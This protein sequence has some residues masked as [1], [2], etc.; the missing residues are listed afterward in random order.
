MSSPTPSSTEE[1]ELVVT[2]PTQG[3]AWETLSSEGVACRGDKL[4]SFLRTLAYFPS[5]LSGCCGTVT[6]VSFQGTLKPKLEGVI[7]PVS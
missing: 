5:L 2:S 3:L 6:S 7:T 4:P 1:A